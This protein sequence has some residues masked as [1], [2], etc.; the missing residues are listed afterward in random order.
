MRMQ[1]QTRRVQKRAEERIRKPMYVK[2]PKDS[3][4]DRTRLFVGGPSH[5]RELEMRAEIRRLIEA[6]KSKPFHVGG[7]CDGA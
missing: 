7:H 2:G 3:S 5:K 4:G 6:E 1:D